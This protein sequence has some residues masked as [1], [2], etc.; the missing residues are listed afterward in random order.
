MENETALLRKVLT[1]YA[2]GVRPSKQVN[3][4]CNMRLENI[5]KLDIVEQTLS[6][7]ATLFVTWK[8]NRLSWNPG[9]WKGLSVI[10]PRNIDIWKPVIVHANSTG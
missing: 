3:V 9:K 8:D 10:Y 2:I 4:T 1:D 5:L 7:M 6:V